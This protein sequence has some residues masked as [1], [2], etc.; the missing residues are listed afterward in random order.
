[1]RR[2][3]AILAVASAAFALACMTPMLAFAVQA[4][5]DVRTFEDAEEWAYAYIEQQEG[6]D[7]LAEGTNAGDGW[8]LTCE[9]EGWELLAVEADMSW[10]SEGA[11]SYTISSGSHLMGLAQLV[12]SGVDFAGKTV[13]LN[14]DVAFVGTEF[15]PIGGSGSNAFNGTFDGQGHSVRGFAIT[16]VADSGRA[17]NIG[18][19]GACGAGSVIKNLSVPAANITVKR[20]ASSTDMI[21]NV[22]AIVGK[23]EGSIEN[24]SSAATVDINVNTPQTASEKLVVRNVGGVAGVVYCNVRDCSFDGSFSLYSNTAATGESD[25]NGR[26]TGINV[27]AYIG[28]VVGYLGDPSTQED[29]QTIVHGSIEGCSFGGSIKSETPCEAG[30]DRFGET[31]KSQSTGI[32]GIVGYS[33]GSVTACSYS[34]DIDAPQGCLVGGIIGSFRC[35]GTAGLGDKTAMDYGSEYDKITCSL[36]STADNTKINGLYAVGGIV[37][38]AGTY[39]VIDECQNKSYVVGQRWNKPFLGGIA[40]QSSG[41]V[42]YCFN[43]GTVETATGGGYYAS[44]LVGLLNQYKTLDGT[45][46]HPTP[47]VYGSINVGKVVAT[48]NMKSAAL[49]G[50]NDGYVHNCLAL[51]GVCVDKVLQVDDSSSGSVVNC[52]FMSAEELKTA[53]ACGLLNQMRVPSGNWDNYFL[54]TGGDNGGYPV[55]KSFA[56]DIATT[57]LSASGLSASCAQNAAYTGKEAT[58]TLDVTFNGEKLVQNADYYVVPQTGA[59]DLQSGG[60]SAGIV[61]IG[62]YAGQV[63]DVCTYGIDKGSLSDCTVTIWTQTFDYT[64]KTIK[65]EDVTVTDAYGNVLPSEWYTYEIVTQVYDGDDP[66]YAGMVMPV[67]YNSPA[68]TVNMTKN[69]PE[70]SKDG[71]L[72]YGYYPVSVKA[73]SSAPYVGETEGL[74]KVKPASLVD[75]EIDEMTLEIDGVEYKYEW[76]DSAMGVFKDGS[77]VIAYTGER[78]QP[79]VTSVTYKGHT[80]VKDQD[81][82]L[83]YG[84]PN[85]DTN[86]A[87]F[88]DYDNVGTNDTNM[89][90]CVTV[91]FISGA[92]PYDFDNYVNMYFV[93]HGANAPAV[94]SIADCRIETSDQ[95]ATGLEVQPVKVYGPDGEELSSEY[96]RVEYDNNIKV[97][98]ASYTV[99]GTRDYTGTYSGTFEIYDGTAAL[100]YVDVDPREW[101]VTSGALAYA[102]ETGLIR[103]YDETHFGPYDTLTRA[104]A[105]TIL[106]R[107]ADPDAEAGYESR[108]AST[109]N[110]TGMADVEDAA[111]YTGA[112]NWAVANGVINGVENDDGTRS[113]DPNGVITR[114]QI[115]T[116]LAN[117]AKTQNGK[118]IASQT[119]ASKLAGMPD[120]S[121]VSDWAAES[122]AWALSVG[123][124][125]GVDND[126]VRYVQPDRGVYR[127]EMAAIMMNCTKDADIISRPDEGGAAGLSVDALTALAAADAGADAEA[128]AEVEAGDGAEVEAEA[129]ADA[130]AVAEAGARADAGAAAHAGSEE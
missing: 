29:A 89:L 118:D 24:C 81:Y 98:T 49:V 124:I 26:S 58:P 40:G 76:Y 90:G 68:K 55:L 129:D 10:Y 78:I 53:D 75:C 61:G 11:S 84:N 6:I 31:I 107:F 37:G 86:S 116:I 91:R 123:V 64:V 7:L 94:S 72:H 109:V 111:W 18:L 19:F 9:D 16:S 38:A 83:V 71:V 60:Y 67:R 85:S 57:S 23:S 125:S 130:D 34:G 50:Q 46:T 96:Y 104:Q 127:C 69:A 3:G 88:I 115:C 95:P 12:N 87:N 110:E 52:E 59:I 119:D 113:F 73:T 114:E 97:G 92:R 25:A 1:M 99:Y 17:Q 93:I 43:S 65:P 54:I 100:G 20:S 32:G 4:P 5:S 121:S 70:W 77:P 44:G 33:Q 21:R 48:N 80:L 102:N 101:Y 13:Y 126:G 14:G 82:R 15:T 45:A 105:A 47:E 122:V 56:S 66:K 22:G 117:Y 35:M 8:E 2:K 63:G 106:W 42:S 41:T 128:E 74:F 28:G 120:A 79:N 112:A 36:S 27:A 103:G 108:Q 62:H 39:T 51:E 30:K